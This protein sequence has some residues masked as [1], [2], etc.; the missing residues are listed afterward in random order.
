MTLQCVIL[1]TLCLFSLQSTLQAQEYEYSKPSWWFGAAACANFNYYRGSTQQLDANFRAPAAFHDGVGVGLYV[2]PLMEYHNPASIWG[3]GLQV[4]Y[5]S[6]GSKYDQI[7]TACNCP[8]DLSTN[9]SYITVEPSLRLA[10][11]K[12]GFYLFGGPR[13]AFNLEKDYTYQLG[14]N[15]NIPQQEASPEVNGELS[16]VNN[17]LLSFQFGAGYDIPLNSQD[18]Q[19]QAVISPFVSFHPYIGQSPR[20]IETWNISTL[21]VGAALK[22]GRG[23]KNPS[24]AI[25]NISVPMPTPQVQFQWFLHKT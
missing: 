6:R 23:R 8:A 12:T 13:I 4:A 9:L 20:S 14:A 25:G 16:D 24:E 10:P 3:F 22:F 15:P 1:S 7:N 18:H 2:A 11:F 19:T 17:T 21:R 5:D